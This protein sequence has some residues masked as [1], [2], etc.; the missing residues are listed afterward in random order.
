MPACCAAVR[1][2]VLSAPAP[3][4]QSRLEETLSELEAVKVALYLVRWGVVDFD[5]RTRSKSDSPVSIPAFFCGV[6][7]VGSRRCCEDI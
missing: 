3:Q 4:L 6:P 2:S 5:R 1:S 7:S